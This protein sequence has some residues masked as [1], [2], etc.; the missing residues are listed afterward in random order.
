MPDILEGGCLCGEVRYRIE[1]P[2]LY[3]D[4]CHCRM[5]QL[6]T[7]APVMTWAAIEHKGL[8]FT[9]SSVPIS[10]RSSAFVTPTFCRTC[11]TKLTF[12]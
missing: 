11:G 2:V 4:H 3:T 12:T 7:G 8:A 6:G 1:V 9:T 10:Y 5:C